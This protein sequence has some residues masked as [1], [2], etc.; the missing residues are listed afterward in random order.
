M[1]SKIDPDGN[2]LYHKTYRTAGCECCYSIQQTTD[3]GF[4]LAGIRI[5][6]YPSRGSSAADVYLIRT[7]DSFGFD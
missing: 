7:N 6:E 2:E 5:K 3:L 1:I 4:F